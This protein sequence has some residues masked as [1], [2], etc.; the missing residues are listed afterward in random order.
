MEGGLAI[1]SLIK[2]NTYRDKIKTAVL[3]SNKYV[4]T[5]NIFSFN[6][7]ILLFYSR[8]QSYKMT[9]ILLLLT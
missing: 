5:Y 9:F 4:P 1:K 7:V 6:Y 2:N 8:N 3:I